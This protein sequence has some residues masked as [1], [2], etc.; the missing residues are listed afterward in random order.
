[1]CSDKKVIAEMDKL[2][3]MREH[4]AKV[5]KFEKAF[6]LFLLTHGVKA[7]YCTF[8]IDGLKYELNN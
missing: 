5:A 3:K 7:E 6:H 8:K 2:K 1:M 4:E